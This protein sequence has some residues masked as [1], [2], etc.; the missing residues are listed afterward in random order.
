MHLSF[1]TTPL[2]KAFTII[3][4]LIVVAVIAI[5]ATLVTV[6]YNEQ[7]AVARDSNRKLALAAYQTGLEQYHAA[8]DTYMVFLGDASNCDFSSLD[9]NPPNYEATV[10]ATVATNDDCVG[11]KGQGWGSIN[12]KNPAANYPNAK[13]SIADVL[14]QEGFMSKKSTDPTSKDFTTSVVTSIPVGQDGQIE[15][16]FK[17]DDYILTVCDRDGNRATKPE[18]AEIF[19]L[20]AQLERPSKAPAS[21]EKTRSL[22]GGAGGAGWQDQRD[23]VVY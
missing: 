13:L 11:Y 23:V 14:N 6:N 9:T 7:R 20:Y 2:K 10:K 12:R 22:C 17:F 18:N 3:E 4:L 16:A 21:A 15:E 1:R 8:K 5:L 19:G